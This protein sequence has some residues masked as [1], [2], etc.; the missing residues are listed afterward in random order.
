MRNVAGDVTSVGN[1]FLFFLGRSALRQNAGFCEQRLE[2][3]GRAHEVD[4]L[5]FKDLGDRADQRIGIAGPEREQQLSE[6]PVGADAAEYLLVLYLPRMRARVM[7]SALKVSINFESS[8]RESQCTL[9]PLLSMAGSVSSLIAA[10]ITSFPCARAA[11]KT[12][13]GKRPLPAMRPSLG[14]E[15]TGQQCTG[16]I[17][18]C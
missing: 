10:T 2:E 15:G 14:A 4:A 8:P 18:Y 16:L 11:S 12:R 5:V 9:V 3:L 7:P 13:K 6:A 17:F 1:V